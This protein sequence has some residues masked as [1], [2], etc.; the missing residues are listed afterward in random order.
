MVDTKPKERTGIARFLFGPGTSERAPQAPTASGARAGVTA[1]NRPAATKESIRA[2]AGSG[3]RAGSGAVGLQQRIEA[4]PSAAPKPKRVESK[5]DTSERA[6]RW[7]AA[8]NKA[9]R[10]E[11]TQEEWD[12]LTEPQ[13]QQVRFNGQ[14]L[15]A[16]DADVAANSSERRE[17]TGLISQLGL[18][19]TLEKDITSG[20]G[21]GVGPAV[22]Y[23]DLFKAQPARPQASN[24][25]MDS[26]TPE[27]LPT[28]QVQADERKQ[29]L[30]TISAKLGEYLAKTA[31]AEAQEALAPAL[32]RGSEYK[33]ATPQAQG[34]YEVTFSSLLDRNLLSQAA[35]SNVAEGLRAAGYDP[36]DFKG[37]VLD[38][39]RMLP[40][41][42]GQSS[43]QDLASWFGS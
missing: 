17:T 23:D 43:T 34:D 14:L 10:R 20:L 8:F 27:A 37:Y 32:A 11:L 25:G 12:R 6:Q 7:A 21:W 13:R 31:P 41:I 36:E 4:A 15:Q 5:P 3:A 29:K 16:F 39:I 22:T 18:A 1:V 40:N 35:W 26:I 9:N 2:S 28:A 38:R 33:F 30:D 19:P 24:V 42:E